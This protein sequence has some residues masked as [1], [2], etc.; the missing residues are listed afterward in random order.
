MH[1]NRL[2]RDDD[3]A[4]H[5][6]LIR[7]HPFA[8][9][10]AQTPAGP[11]VAHTPVLSTGDGALQFHLARG[12]ALTRHIEGRTVLITFTGAH[13][14][15][16][17]RWYTGVDHV[18]TWNYSALEC[19]GP[20]RRMHEEGLLAFLETFGDREEERIVEG[21]PWRMASVSEQAKSALLRGVVGFE[22][23]IAVRRETF[24]LSQKTPAEDRARVVDGLRKQGNPLLAEAMETPQ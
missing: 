23:E 2:F 18:P 7:E 10:F 9:V 3:R 4:R 11:R 14:Y 19:E 24:K 12:N 22:L 1:P 5:E 17:P 6:A 15:I 21:V 8:V 16:S 13:G 20:V